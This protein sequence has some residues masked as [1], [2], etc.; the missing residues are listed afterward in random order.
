MKTTISILC[1]LEHEILTWAINADIFGK[2]E[3]N[4]PTG[5]A[6]WDRTG[7]LNSNH[8]V[9]D[10]ETPHVANYTA[11]ILLRLKDLSGDA[12][13]KYAETAKDLRKRICH[14]LKSQGTS[15]HELLFKTAAS[16]T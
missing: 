2:T 7:V 6:S 3:S 5:W 15:G 13:D 1:P 11:F 4:F 16:S 12:R 10:W 9:L 8:L 14:S